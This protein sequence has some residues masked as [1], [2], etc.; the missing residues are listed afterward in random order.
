MG[1]DQP[2]ALTGHRTVAPIFGAASA[3]PASR[4]ERLTT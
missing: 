1:P 3:T 4:F 2:V